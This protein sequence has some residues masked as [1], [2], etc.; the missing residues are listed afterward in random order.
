M[1]TNPS[2]LPVADTATGARYTGV[3]ILLHWVLAAALIGLFVLGMYMADLPFSPTRL[4]YYNWHKWAGMTVLG[5]SALRLVWRITHPAPAL[6]AA[7]ESAM[8]AWQRAAHHGT[9]HALYLLFFLV[10]LAGWLYSSAA[11]F[12]VVMFGVFPLPDL[13]AASPELAETLKPV[14]KLL[15]FA[16][17]LLVVLHVGAAVKHQLIDRD[18]LMQRMLPGARG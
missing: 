17:G 5:L 4:K 7:I 18:G 12:P 16:L 6:P 11:G 10:P 14:H 2:H 3:A 8:P 13:I 9:H 1:T 15:A